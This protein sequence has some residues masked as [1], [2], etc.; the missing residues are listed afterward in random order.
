MGVYRDAP[1]IVG[2]G[3]PVARFQR[4]FDAGG[5]AGDRF[6]HAVVE[7]F[8]GKM[9]QRAFVRAANIHARPAADR[10]QPFQNLDRRGVIIGGR[11]G[12]GGKQVIGHDSKL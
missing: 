8:T 6:V 3:E 12:A 9:V 10:L 2:D 1:A 7:H 4:H 11:D 5:V